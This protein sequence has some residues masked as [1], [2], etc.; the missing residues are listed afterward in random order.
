MCKMIIS[1]GFFLIFDIFIFWAVR[2]GGGGK[3]GVKGQK[4]AQDDKIIL[5]VELDISGTIHD[6]RGSYDQVIIS[7]DIYYIF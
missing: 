5:S 3:G 4:L 1:P 6:I 2:G 7:P